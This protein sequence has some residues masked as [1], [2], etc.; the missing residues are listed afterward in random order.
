MRLPLQTTKRG[1]M[2]I[3]LQSHSFALYSGNYQLKDLTL[4]LILLARHQGLSCLCSVAPAVFHQLEKAIHRLEE[5]LDL[6]LTSYVHLEKLP[7]DAAKASYAQRLAEKLW[8]SKQLNQP[9]LHIIHY[10]QD[11]WP[12]LT[13]LIR[14]ER[15]KTKIL[16]NRPI[17]TIDL[18]SAEDFLPRIQTL[19][20]IHPH[21]S[22]GVDIHRAGEKLRQELGMGRD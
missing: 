3:P 21:Y 11:F 1:Q 7:A 2:P 12:R 22:E 8:S 5:L 20:S 14:Q 13:D 18:Y 15:K 6:D 4:D 19:F 17:G 16:K 10:Y 9:S